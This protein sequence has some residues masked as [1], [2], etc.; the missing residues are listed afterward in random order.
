M[1]IGVKVE[2]EGAKEFRKA[3]TAA[4]KEAVDG[5]KA[6]NKAAAQVVKLAAIPL[7]PVLTGR[8]RDSI[9]PAGTKTAG[10]VRAA[11]ARIPWGPVIHWGWAAKGIAP[12]PFML[13]ALDSRRDEIT[14]KYAEQVDALIRKHGL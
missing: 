2:V 14:K 9:R 4:G 10:I 13:D 6:A 12:R 8:L 7:A 3:A 5:L 11:G 1:S